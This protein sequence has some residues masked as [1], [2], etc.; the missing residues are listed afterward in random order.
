MSLKLYLS[1][2][3]YDIIKVTQHKDRLMATHL[4]ALQALCGIALKI[5]KINERIRTIMKK[6]T[7][8]LSGIFAFMIALTASGCNSSGRG[9]NTDSTEAV[10]AA[11]TPDPDKE[12][13][14]DVD[15]EGMAD[16]DAVD[17]ANEAGTGP[18]YVPGQ[19]AGV[20]KALCYYDLAETQPELAELLAQ[21]YGGTIETEIT[22]SGSA[23]YERL[24]VLIA[25]GDSPDIT[26]YDW[27][28]YPMGTSKNMF[29]ELDE[30]LDID[31]PL[32]SGEKEIIDN[33]NYLGKHYYFPSDIESNFAMIYNKSV[34]EEFGMQDPM[35]LYFEGNWNWDTFE[36]LIE[37]WVQQGDDYVGFTG[38]SWSSV[39]FVNTTGVKVIDMTGTEIINNLKN[40]DVQRAMDWLTNLKKQNLIGDGFVNPAEAFIDGKLLFLGMGLTWGYESAQESFYKNNIDGEIAVV[41]LPR[42][43]NADSYYLPSDSFGFL[44]PAGADN[45]QG[46]VQWILCGR[47]YETDPD[48]VAATRA[49]KMD[50]GPVYFPKCPKCKYNFTENGN[51]D[52]AVCPECNTARKQK[53]KATYNEE[54]M[55][56]IDDMTNPEKFK[57]VFDNAL[58]FNDDFSM[59]LVGTEETIFDGPIYYGSSF[60]QLRD[61]NYHTIEA[62]LEPYREALREGIS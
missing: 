60:T 43:P 32:W 25:A 34:L 42:D 10:T 11:T 46:G 29:T 5:I 12:L 50:M 8:F 54:Q 45:I 56:V 15:W 13:E 37:Q 14:N 1:R 58:G 41:P 57:Y 36:E 39:M 62:Y 59:L 4:S 22:T 2:L 51:D 61:A 3:A 18:L 28:A 26:R 48:I 21:R 7:R 20:V 27:M 6:H 55:Q 49:E 19:K 44:V 30:W 24:G 33:F 31:S 9:G 38:G 16:I 47:I 40:Q 17:E 52:L 23:Y 35:D 53:Y